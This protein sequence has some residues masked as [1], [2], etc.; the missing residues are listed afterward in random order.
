MSQHPAGSDPM[1]G[2]Q[3]NWQAMIQDTQISSPSEGLPTKYDAGVVTPDWVM[4]ALADSDPRHHMLTEESGTF[5][6]NKVGHNIFHRKFH[7]EGPPQG[8]VLWIHGMGGHC[9]KLRHKMEAEAFNARG[10]AW[11]ALDHQAHGYSGGYGHQTFHHVDDLVDDII[12]LIQ[13]ALEELEDPALRFVLTGESLGG[14]LTILTALRLQQT[15]HPLHDRFAGSFL[16]CPAIVAN[17]PN[18]CVE[19]ILRGCCLPCCPG[20][21]CLSPPAPG[22]D[23]KEGSTKGPW[24][25]YASKDCYD[26]EHDPMM[27]HD[28]FP[29]VTGGA[30]IDMTRRLQAEAVRL[31][32]PFMIVHGLADG[33]VLP[34]GSKMMSEKAAYAKAELAL[35][36]PNPVL[37]LPYGR[38]S[39]LA[40]FC[41]DEVRHAM[42]DWCAHRLEQPPSAPAAGDSAGTEDLAHR[43]CCTAF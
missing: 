29:L 40:D 14:A 20:L 17:L 33:T 7:P 5:F 37:L 39:L 3:S 31:S 24:S 16:V 34:E 11:Y 36:R 6:V 4:T 2:F 10:L 9:N 21:T 32:S 25:M 35:G 18:L 15:D 30:L 22:Q 26:F 38:H 23:A 28:R 8:L 12:Q 27:W 19:A 13:L 42:V 43:R 41:S 1:A